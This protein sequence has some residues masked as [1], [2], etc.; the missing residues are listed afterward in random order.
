VAGFLLLDVRFPRS[1][2]L[3]VREAGALL[4]GL[5]FRHGLRGGRG[6]AEGLDRL[7]ALVGE[8]SIGEIL[9]EGLHEFLDM[10]QRQLIAVTDDLAG[11]FFGAQAQGQSQ[12]QSGPSGSQSQSQSGSGFEW[13]PPLPSLPPAQP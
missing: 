1:V 7:R 8:L 6:A 3:C 11:T 12:S 4:E 2:A 5:R 10:I 9:K 13:W